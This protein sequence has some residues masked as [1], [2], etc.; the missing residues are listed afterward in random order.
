M[1]LLLAVED[2]ALALAV[3]LALAFAFRPCFRLPLEVLALAL[4]DMEVE[5]SAEEV[6]TFVQADMAEIVDCS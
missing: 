1:G 6:D 2:K 5:A 3:A 4:G